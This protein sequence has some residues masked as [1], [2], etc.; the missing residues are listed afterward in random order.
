MGCDKRWLAWQQTNFVESLLQKAQAESF[1]EC[2]LCID[3]ETAAW[4]QLAARYGARLLVDEQPDCGPLEGLHQALGAMQSGQALV[5]SCDMPFVTFAVLRPLLAALPGHRAALPVTGTQ[6]QHLA[7]LYRRELLPA[8]QQA[9]AAGHRS[10]HGM[11][12]GE[13]AAFVD[14]TAHT[15]EFFN[16]NTPQ[17]LRLAY[18]RVR[19][20]ERRVP[21]VSVSAAHSNSGKTTFI[22][23]LLPLLTARG[24]RVS[25]VKSDRHALK[26]D[27]EGTDSHR[28]MAAGAQAVA[29]V[30]PG[31]LLLVQ[32]TGP[33]R[34]LFAA[35]QR[36]EDADLVL[37][38][39]RTHGEQPIVQVVRGEEPLADA[40]EAIALV[41]SDGAAKAA[42]ILQ[43]SLQQLE[44]AASVVCF[45]GGLEDEK[46]LLP[47][48][49]C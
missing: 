37:L 23:Q 19:N 40:S 43:L 11:L 30:S 6:H 22:E 46:G 28:F 20:L 33:E 31:Q 8:V 16:V 5:L 36:M 13:D 38:E 49:D 35:A 14:C 24:L 9:L 10:L 7:A 15:A 47:A 26:L 42:D 17:A 45:L 25:V 1:A 41:L 4:Q 21:V 12:A 48:L 2:L 18:G 3:C 32:R 29:V 34:D 27:P 44:L 39:S